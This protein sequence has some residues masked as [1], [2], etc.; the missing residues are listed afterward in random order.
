MHNWNRNGFPAEY[1]GFTVKQTKRG[2]YAIDEATDRDFRAEELVEVEDYIDAIRWDEE[3]DAEWDR[4]RAN[5]EAAGRRLDA[6]L[7]AVSA[8]MEKVK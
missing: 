4:E 6:T 2:Y 1:R 3:Q 8:E 5:A 7:A